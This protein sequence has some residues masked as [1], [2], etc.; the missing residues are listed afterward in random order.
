MAGMKG[1]CQ[2]REIR[3]GNGVVFKGLANKKDPLTGDGELHLTNGSIYRG[4]ILKGQP[5]GQGEMVWSHEA[6]D[7]LNSKRMDED[8]KE[9]V[10]NEQNIG[11]Q[12]SYKGNWV[13]GKMEG[14]GKYS[15]SEGEFYYGYF[16]NNIPNGHGIRKFANGDLYDGKYADG[17]QTGQGMFIC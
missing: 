12:K 14:L 6:S 4:Q 17:Y 3:L 15:L 16:S 7:Q 1:G 8:D 10:T 5:H 11:F 2:Y 13:Q 9:I